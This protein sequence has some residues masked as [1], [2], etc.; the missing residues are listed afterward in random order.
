MVAVSTAAAAT[1]AVACGE[2]SGSAADASFEGPPADAQSDAS[3]LGIGLDVA[4]VDSGQTLV[5][6]ADPDAGGCSSLYGSNV[7]CFGADATPY[8]TYLAPD[9]GINVGQCPRPPD[10]LP[11]RGEGSCGYA[12]CGPLLPSAAAAIV[13][14]AGVHLGDGGEDWT[15]CFLVLQACAP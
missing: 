5:P 15:C 4:A 8:R 10:F 12:A 14:A 1:G 7:V 3:A 9:A 11:S 2:A 6:L 13:T